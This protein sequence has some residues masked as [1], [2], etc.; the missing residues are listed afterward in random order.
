MIQSESAAA[1]RRPIVT[2]NAVRFGPSSRDERRNGMIFAE[3]ASFG[4]ERSLFLGRVMVITHM[5]LIPD[6]M[7]RW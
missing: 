4:G 1:T 6:H 3:G 2:S 7:G 5:P